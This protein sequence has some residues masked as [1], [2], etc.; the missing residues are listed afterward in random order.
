M[1]ISQ[2]PNTHTC[3]GSVIL[4]ESVHRIVDRRVLP[5]SLNCIGTFS[6]PEEESF[7][8]P[9]GQDMFSRPGSW[10]RKSLTEMQAGQC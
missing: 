1:K 6:R 4:Q 5:E 10:E 3:K 9:F 2:T 8:S 7:M